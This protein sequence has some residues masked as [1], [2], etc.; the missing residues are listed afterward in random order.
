MAGLGA[1]QEGEHWE[2]VYWTSLEVLSDGY[3]C[4]TQ[5]ASEDKETFRFEPMEPG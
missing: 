1:R 5:Q 3:A 4:I 2:E